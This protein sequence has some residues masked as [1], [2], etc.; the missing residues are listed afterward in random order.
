MMIMEDVLIPD[1]A[2]IARFTRKTI[3]RF[4]SLTEAIADTDE[5]LRCFVNTSKVAVCR[6]V[7]TE[8]ATKTLDFDGLFDILE[9]VTLALV[10]D[11]LSCPC[12]TNELPKLTRLQKEDLL[13]FETFNKVSVKELKRKVTLLNF[14]IKKHK[15]TVANDEKFRQKNIKYEKKLTAILYRLHGNTPMKSRELSALQKKRDKAQKDFNKIRNARR[16]NNGV[17]QGIRE[18]IKTASDD[19]VSNITNQIVDR[20]DYGL[21]GCLYDVLD[22]LKQNQVRRKLIELTKHINKNE[23]ADRLV[24]HCSETYLMRVNVQP[25]SAKNDL[26]LTDISSSAGSIGESTIVEEIQLDTTTGEIST[27]YPACG[28]TSSGEISHDTG[29][30]TGDDWNTYTMGF[31]ERHMEEVSVKVKTEPDRWLP[32]FL[33]IQRGMEFKRTAH[34]DEAVAFGYY[35]ASRKAQRQWGFYFVDST[36]SLM[37]LYRRDRD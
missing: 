35:R 18:K 31:T 34:G 1:I 37:E 33:D 36:L 4:V 32:G 17:E 30:C 16:I 21:E 5:G 7:M 28:G 3:D 13:K 2:S 27:A 24:R 9:K 29:Y 11:D 6:T 25:E 12:K 23:M 15:Q 8:L 10:A 22:T 19:V 14:L 20:L 26:S